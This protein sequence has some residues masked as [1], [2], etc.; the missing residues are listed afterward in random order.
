MKKSIL[1]GFL[2]SIVFLMNAIPE[3]SG[4]NSSVSYIVEVTLLGPKLYVRMDGEPNIFTNSFPGRVGQGRIIVTNGGVDGTLTISSAIIKINGNQIFG[5]SDFNQ[6]VQPMEKIINLQEQN[7]ISIELRSKPNSNIV[8]QITQEIS[9]AA[10]G[11][12]GPN[13]GIIEVTNSSSPYYGVRIEVPA[14]ALAESKIIYINEDA[15]YPPVPEGLFSGENPIVLQP[16]GLIFLKPIKMIIPANG[17]QERIYYVYDEIDEEWDFLDTVLIR[18][19]DT[20]EIVLSHFSIVNWICGGLIN[21]ATFDPCSEYISYSINVSNSNAPGYTAAEIAAAIKRAIEAW[22]L[23]L[24]DRITFIQGFHGYVD[25]NFY[26]SDKDF[27]FVILDAIL[28]GETL[29]LCS[30]NAITG[31]FNIKFNGT[32]NIIWSAG[33]NDLNPRVSISA[34]ALHE[35]GHALGLTHTCPNGYIPLIKEC[36]GCWDGPVM[37]PLLNISRNGC[38][39]L[40]AD[41][42]QRIKELYPECSWPNL[43]QNYSFEQGNGGWPDFWDKISNA[44]FVWDS[45][46]SHTGFRSVSISDTSSPG[47]F[48]GLQTSYYIAVNPSKNYNLSAW[49]SWSEPKGSEFPTIRLSEFDSLGNH[50]YTYN[51]YLTWG[52]QNPWDPHLWKDVNFHSG[53]RYV[54]IAVGRYVNPNGQSN[55]NATLRWDTIKLLEY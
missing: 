32:G 43:I 33:L 36:V 53:T 26:W 29:G 20:Y 5:T 6:N 31:D 34:V 14:G 10:G 9:A 22:D 51:L 17:N 3:G 42:S 45:T 7:S 48:Y 18:Q 37:S 44:T 55:P 19:N 15:I 27:S 54:K 49:Y 41:D 35:I 39:L 47:V 28:P 21:C 1:I 16:S 38:Q 30:Y 2:I 12:I 11:I 24:G 52:R 4:S 23:A 50:I 25:I 13:G 40:Q 8:V 46:K